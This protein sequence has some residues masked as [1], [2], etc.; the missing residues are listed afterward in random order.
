MQTIRLIVNV[1]LTVLV[2]VAFGT[3]LILFWEFFAGGMLLAVGL[4]I[5]IVRLAKSRDRQNN[6]W[7][8]FEL[9]G[10]S[11]LVA[12]L[13]CH[14]FF[15]TWLIVPWTYFVFNKI[16]AFIVNLPDPVLNL[17]NEYIYIN[18]NNALRPVDIVAVQEV[19]FG[20]PMLLLSLA[21]GIGACTPLFHSYC[22]FRN[23]IL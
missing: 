9:S 14:K 6:F 10:W 21:G 3:F 19:S 20:L 2:T 13:I 7:K 5:G 16:E 23:L 12:Y 8:G 11:M 1:I 22:T 15:F 18:I 17:F 4:Q